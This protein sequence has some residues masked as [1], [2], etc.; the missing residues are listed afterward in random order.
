LR[1]I[2]RV[3]IA[4]LPAVC[5]A[6]GAGGVWISGTNAALFQGIQA[7]TAEL[8]DSL[9]AWTTDQASVVAVAAWMC[10]ALP[11]LPRAAASVLLS[12]PAGVLIIRGLKYLIDEA[13]PQVVLPPDAIHVIGVELT[14]LSFPSGHTATAF[15]VA[16][17][18]IYS[19]SSAG[20]RIAALPVLAIAAVIGLS[21]IAVGAHWPVDVLAGAA[22]GW[23][24]GL[25][26]VWWSDRWRFWENRRGRWML[27]ILGVVAG[28]LRLFVETGYPSA[29]NFAT[30]LGALA[31]AVSL[32]AAWQLRGRTC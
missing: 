26:G 29:G 6:L 11:R 25:V 5:L 1:P 13:R 30:V 23:I 12:W 28:M 22:L 10:F 27:A 2:G 9:W 21:R 24:C 16:A 18:L 31:V 8:P 4:M 7:K 14:S 19:L 3:A 32:R 15:A 20:R 17:A